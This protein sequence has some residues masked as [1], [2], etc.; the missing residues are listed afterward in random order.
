MQF[1]LDR[2]GSPYVRVPG[3]GVCFG[4]LPVTKFQIEAWLCQPGSR[5]DAWYAEVLS[6]HPRLDRA[7]LQ[8]S[9]EYLRAFVGGVTAQDGMDYANWLGSGFRIP[10][11]DEWKAA[12]RGLAELI[13]GFSIPD[14]WSA[15]AKQLWRRL[16]RPHARLCD[17]MLFEGG[18]GEWVESREGEYGLLGRPIGTLW[19]SAPDDVPMNPL[20]ADAH[21][22]R[23][24]LRMVFSPEGESI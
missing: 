11:Q 23:H 6:L 9:K 4:L 5:D 13:G 16:E 17:S 20:V 12:R 24:G 8:S 22:G 2:T 15:E 10:R 21:D 3:S 7:H 1:T 18:F 14:D 19:P